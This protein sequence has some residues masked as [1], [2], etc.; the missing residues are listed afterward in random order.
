[1]EAYLDN[2]ATTQ[3]CEEAIS[4]MVKAL[5]N[6][7]GNPSSMHAKGQQA[8]KLLEQARC[9]VSKKLFCREEEIYFT[10]GGTEGNNIVIFGSVQALKRQG[11]RIVT[12]GIEHP[13]VYEPIKQLE[14]EGF[15]VVR[16]KVDGTGRIS[17]EELK[18]AINSDTILV[19]IMAVNNEVGTIQPI[20]AAR[21]AVDAAR[22]PALV[23]CDIVQ[24]FGKMPIK[25]SAMGVDLLTLSSHKVHGPKGTGAIYVK[26]GVHL[27][28]RHCG[29]TQEGKLR[30]GTQPMPAIVGFGAAVKALPNITFELENA[31]KLKD[32]F[33]G[34]LKHLDN[35]VINSPP[36]ALPFV[37]NL[38]VIGVLSEHMLNFLSERG[39]YVSSGSACAKGQ[40]SRVLKEMGLDDDR[41][42]SPL[43]ISFSR[44]TTKEHLNMLLEGISE[45]QK[46]FLRR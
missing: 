45:G 26:K 33:V 32:Y 35:V 37:V 14:S 3:L 18:D 25:P 10:S 42:R 23:H 9:E 17:E 46:K 30:P 44:F 1:M 40:Q 21:K 13:S 27:V 6:S 38:S 19:S 2:S 29:G 15:E 7:W 24:A 5:N 4:A 34:E 36:D 28:P 12:T 20:E 8:E 31:G 11:K 41:L 16:L 43:R 39:V 22:A